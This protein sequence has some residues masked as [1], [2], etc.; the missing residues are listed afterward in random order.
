MSVTF[1]FYRDSYCG[2]LDEPSFR[3]AVNHAAALVDWL[4]YPNEPVASNTV[5]YQRAI[6]A[7][8]DSYA[9][10]GLQSVK[11]MR[12]GSFSIEAGTSPH[13]EAREA[14]MAELATACP[15][16]LYKGL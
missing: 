11:Y 3:S 5:H 6:C 2:T 14:A 7:A 16:L 15:S 8:V 1:D 13:S 9:A 10:N 4:I 12:I